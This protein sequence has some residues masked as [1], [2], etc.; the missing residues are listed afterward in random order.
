MGI[1]NG[2]SLAATYVEHRAAF[3]GAFDAAD[4]LIGP[5]VG[6][7]TLGQNR[8]AKMYWG[9]QVPTMKP[10]VG[11][12]QFD[13][14]DVY[15]W[16]IAIAKYGAGLEI[17]REDITDDNLG[18]VSPYIAGLGVE[19]R[20]HPGRKLTELLEAGD[21][22]LCYDGQFFFDTDHKDGD[23]PTQSNK[24]TGAL[25]ETTLQTMRQ[26]MARLKDTKG[27]PM[28][29]R[30]THI[31]IP[32]ELEQTAKKIVVAEFGANGSSNVEKG[33]V[34]I[35][36]LAHLTSAV[37]WYGADLSTPFRPLMLFWRERPEF[38][39]QDSLTDE[40]A[41]IREV[42]RYKVRS[43]FGYGYGLWQFAAM[44]TGV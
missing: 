5:L 35:I 10:F 8:S 38:A 19:A 12:L 36:V 25:T 9:G 26:T 15:N 43:R 4:P 23:G 40:Q 27:R 29:R 18:W 14:I 28:P 3:Q 39:A 2:A 41:F 24:I 44:S 11:D 34:Q 16:E 13:Q 7:E 30:L 1:I 21:T 32:P 17:K 33:A 31:I 6:E 42:Y 37:K 22:S 20:Q